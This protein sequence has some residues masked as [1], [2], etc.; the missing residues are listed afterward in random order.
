MKCGFF[1][2]FLFFIPPFCLCLDLPIELEPI[3]IEKESNDPSFPGSLIS[4]D[5]KGLPFD[6]CEGILEYSSGLD[7]RKRAGF[8]IQQ[9]LSI[10]G[11]VF[12][13]NKV[14]VNG[15]EIND[16]QTGH[17]SLEIPFT[18][19]DLQEVR[20]KKNEQS[21]NFVLKKPLSSGGFLRSSFGQHA[22]FENLLSVNFPVKDLKNRIS[23][24]RKKS[25][26][27]RRDT[28]FDIYNMSFDS[29]YETELKEFEFI[30]GLGKKE[31]GA[32]GFY[33]WPNFTQEEEHIVQHFSSMRALFKED[34]FNFELM[35]FFRKH[36]DKFVLDRHN[37]SFYTNYHTTYIYGLDSKID[38][39][40]LGLWLGLGR[41]SEKISS[42]N[43]NDH[44]RR[45]KSFSVGFNP[46]EVGNFMF[47]GSLKACS[48]SNWGW[49]SSF[50]FNAGYFLSRNLR[51]KFSFDKTHRL[52]S[53]TELF[54]LSPSNQGN[55]F[56]EVQKMNNFQWSLEYLNADFRSALSLFLREQED[57][58]DWVKN[59]Q[60]AAWQAQ[61][62]GDINSR[63]VEIDF[64]IDFKDFF[65]QAIAF[66]YSF[67]EL[68]QRR[69]Y[70]YSKYLFNFL[71]HRL[72]IG[73]KIDIKDYL[74][75]RPV[76]I[77]EKPKERPSRTVF[78]LNITYKINN[79][80]S[81]F[82]EAENLLD[83]KFQ[84]LEGIDAGPRWFKGGI[85]YK[86]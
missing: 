85:S 54:Y 59:L 56:L 19:A 82:L 80:F 50:G 18:A 41:R 83:S 37:P 21:V 48:Y 75:L 69:S 38:F 28:D 31:F 32:N 26:G 71:K 17:Y 24:E 58:I 6:S 29:F 12:E 9:D 11:S 40:E 62:V 20:L 51:L 35:P 74:T 66:K 14:L 43:L 46:R 61:N 7:L 33:A 25:K 45:L 22:L 16:P 72:L 23:F 47:S 1:I 57:T 15:L 2:F 86:F 73:P 60:G 30:Y 79:D 39:K 42:T 81:L 49:V 76:V 64:D 4:D 13:D 27:A 77:F 67:L 68:D 63:G 44:A 55:P 70:R 53:F 65:L 3:V 84:E 10:R 52:P 78:N 36:F 8:A 34:H 5:L